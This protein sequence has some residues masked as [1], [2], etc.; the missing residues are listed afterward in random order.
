MY[1][2]FNHDTDLYDTFPFTIMLKPKRWFTL[3]NLPTIEFEKS[4]VQLMNG[5]KILTNELLK[6]QKHLLLEY[7]TANT[8]IFMECTEIL[9]MIPIYMMP[10]LLLLR[11]N[12]KDVIIYFGWF[13]N[14][15]IWKEFFYS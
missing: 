7:F 9:I 2:N 10:F 11:W 15:W 13:T 4:F 6:W 12:Q 1:W 3:D 5:P 14:F 8:R